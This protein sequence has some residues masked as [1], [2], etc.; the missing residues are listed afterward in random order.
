MRQSKIGILGGLVM[1]LTEL[2]QILIERGIV[3]SMRLAFVGLILFFWTTS[4]FAVSCTSGQLTGTTPGPGGVTLCAGGGTH[5]CTC[6]GPFPQIATG[7]VQVSG[8]GSS[9][10]GGGG[11]VMCMTE[12]AP[13]KAC[14]TSTVGQI[15]TGGFCTSTALGCMCK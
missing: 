6:T 14:T 4:S 10:G 12:T 2:S 3:V 11:P 5:C 1:G 9:G 13:S 15:C 8:G 7:C